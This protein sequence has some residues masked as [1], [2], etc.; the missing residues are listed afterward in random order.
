METS[1]DNQGPDN[2]GPD[3]WGLTVAKKNLWSLALIESPEKKHTFTS[4]SW[5]EN[6]NKN[7]V[8]LLTCTAFHLT[9]SLQF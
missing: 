2:Q 7:L 6:S 4:E 8:P 1:P 9:P 3:N 5:P